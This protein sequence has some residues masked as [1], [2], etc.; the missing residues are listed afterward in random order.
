MKAHLAVFMPEFAVENAPI[1]RE[2][3][4]GIVVDPTSPAA[5]AE[6]L[7]TLADDPERFSAAT[8]GSGIPNIAQM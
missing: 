4:C 5:I 8:T 3:R 2:A 7:D 6:A 1:V